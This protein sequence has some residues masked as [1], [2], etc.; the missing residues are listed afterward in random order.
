MVTVF[1]VR[2]PECMDM[3]VGAGETVL[4]DEEVWHS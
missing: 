2:V 4:Y 3:S 1:I